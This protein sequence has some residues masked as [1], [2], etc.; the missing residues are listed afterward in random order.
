[1]DVLA[2][3]ILIV[4]AAVFGVAAWATKSLE[5]LGLCL[6]VIG[7]ICIYTVHGAIVS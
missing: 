1:M 5:A 7:V 2:F 4:A 3:I 6:F